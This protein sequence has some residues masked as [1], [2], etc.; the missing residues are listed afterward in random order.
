MKSYPSIINVQI[1]HELN[2][3]KKHN[4]TGDKSWDKNIFLLTISTLH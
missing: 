1:P 2:F 3:H 4:V